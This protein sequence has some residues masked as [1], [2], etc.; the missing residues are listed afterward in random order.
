MPKKPKIDK[1]LDNFFKNI[2][3]EESESRPKSGSKA[4]KQTLSPSV[5]PKPAQKKPE[6]APGPTKL[7]TSTLIPREPVV[8]QENEKPASSYSVNIQT[9]Y[10]DWSTLHVF[11]ET[12]QRQWTQD[13]ELLVKQVSDQLS[14][15]LEN[16]RL[17]QEA[18][19]FKLGI[20]RT[21]Y[22][23]YHY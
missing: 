2:N 4:R 9:G 1:R 14:L 6:E 19:K 18:Q 7:H 5:D 15:A 3:P 8:T 12:N 11:D 10:Q 23:V 17:F 13:E 21:D 22:A 20:D 16:A